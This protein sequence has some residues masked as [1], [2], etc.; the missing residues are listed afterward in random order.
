MA[1]AAISVLLCLLRCFSPAQSL[2]LDVFAMPSLNFERV[3]GTSS[4]AGKAENGSIDHGSAIVPYNEVTP[5]KLEDAA[6]PLHIPEEAAGEGPSPVEIIWSTGKVGIHTCKATDSGF[7][8]NLLKVPHF[9]LCL[10]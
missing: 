3:K 9:K 6:G 7:H 10:A 4:A 2:G 8:A 1:A 5:A